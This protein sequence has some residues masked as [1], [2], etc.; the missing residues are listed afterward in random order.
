[1]N[2]F[3]N[4]ERQFLSTL[5]VTGKYILIFYLQNINYQFED[6][7]VLYLLKIKKYSFKC[8]MIK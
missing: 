6:T 7:A 8:L 1:M 5:N 2:L 3:I 4:Y